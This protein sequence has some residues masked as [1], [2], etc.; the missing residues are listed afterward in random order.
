MTK[1]IVDDA[2]RTK[3]DGLRELV[4][5]CD[6]SGRTLGFFHPLLRTTDPAQPKV[7]SPLTDEEIERRRQEQ[8][9]R[10][11]REILDDLGQS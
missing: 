4:E 5:L 3:L 9:G 11:L 2:F 7:H 8:T 10:P 6:Q 1:V